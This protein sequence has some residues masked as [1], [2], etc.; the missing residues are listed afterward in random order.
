MFL[1]AGSAGAG[2][3]LRSARPYLMTLSV[4]L[5]IFG[6]WQASRATQCGARPNYLSLALLW[7]AALFTGLS[8]LVP[9]A[10]ADLLAG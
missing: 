2:A 6:F 9:Q 3:F 1:A 10:L 5:V 4:A 7:I 8:L